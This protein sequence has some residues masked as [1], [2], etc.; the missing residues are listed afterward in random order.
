M[1]N[2]LSGV[3]GP[4]M[5]VKKGLLYVV[6][7]GIC[8]STFQ[9]HGWGPNSGVRQSVTYALAA[10]MGISAA[11]ALYEKMSKRN[12]QLKTDK[13]EEEINDYKSDENVKKYL[14]QIADL[15]AKWDNF[16]I[17]AVSCLDGCNTVESESVEKVIGC[18]SKQIKRY[19]VTADEFQDG[20]NK[21]IGELTNKLNELHIK[22]E[23]LKS[24]PQFYQSATELAEKVDVILKRLKDYNLLFQ[25]HKAYIKL[26]DFMDQGLETEYAKEIEYAYL[27][28]ANWDL[29]I[30]E[31]IRGKN[32]QVLFPYLFYAQGLQSQLTQLSKY[33][34]NLT[35]FKAY[36]FQEQKITRAKY[37]Y[38][39]LQVIL[40]FAST[41]DTFMREKDAKVG[42]DREEQKIQMELAERKELLRLETKERE[43][44][45]AQQNALAEAKV[46]EQRNKEKNLANEKARLD[47]EKR[48][49]EYKSK[50]NVLELARIHEGYGI[51]QALDENNQ[52][53]RKDYDSLNLNQQKLVR[54]IEQ[55]DAE[56][57]N[58]RIK[59]NSLQSDVKGTHSTN[60]ELERHARSLELRVSNVAYAI[61]L[62]RSKVAN[63][64]FNPQS[65]HGLSEY[66]NGLQ[67]Q[68]RQ[69]KTIVS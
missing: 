31:I 69:L 39:A 58:L 66:I 52:K 25:E 26:Q 53:W 67:E 43:S 14:L 33:L 65:V 62:L 36:P 41:A 30:D 5:S 49:L 64:P 68:I 56:L 12:L 22:S 35:D 61:D 20:I 42:Y 59:L 24:K 11:W 63:P 38:D 37:V 23:D 1:N 40:Q 32:S 16:V 44:K 8:S 19:R 46:I 50:E 2:L 45:I 57:K 6:I 47:K 18:I 48:E 55:R 17:E 29:I 10:G 51:K 3:S 9:A 54:D 60:T 13:L 34:S 21:G 28:V 27:E 15:A 7:I 4:G